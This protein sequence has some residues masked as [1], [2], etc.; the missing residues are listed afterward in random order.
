MVLIHDFMV[1]TMVWKLHKKHGSGPCLRI[2][3]KLQYGSD[4][5]YFN[6]FVWNKIIFVNNYGVRSA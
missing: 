2:V 4:P 6:G 3:L 1:L 5:W